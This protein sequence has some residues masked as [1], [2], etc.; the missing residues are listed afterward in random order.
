MKDPDFIDAVTSYLVTGRIDR[1]NPSDFPSVYYC[2]GG[3]AADWWGMSVLCWPALSR[4]NNDP[5]ADLEGYITLFST[6]DRPETQ[7]P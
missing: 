4:A 2:S 7:N 1:R 6:P 5:W 3:S